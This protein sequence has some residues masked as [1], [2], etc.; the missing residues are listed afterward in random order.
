MADNT[1]IIQNEVFEQKRSGTLD[2]QYKPFKEERASASNFQFPK[3][4]LMRKA[5]CLK[6]SKCIKYY[7]KR[8]KT[9][10]KCFFL[11]F[12]DLLTSTFL[13]TTQVIFWS[14]SEEKNFSLDIHSSF[15]L[16]IVLF[17]FFW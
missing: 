6:S 17:V 15:C 16:K 8:E 10:L 4:G 14:F 11:L 3:N 13:P 5:S 1:V 7:N 9:A 12:T 2:K